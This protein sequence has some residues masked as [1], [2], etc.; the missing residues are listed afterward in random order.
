MPARNTVS[1]KLKACQLAPSRARAPSLAV[2]ALAGGAVLATSSCSSNGALAGFG[3]SSAAPTDNASVD[4]SSGSSSGGTSGF[5]SRGDEAGAG[6]PSLPPEMKVESAFRSPV[7]TGQV[8]WVANP[9]SGRVAYIDA[10]NFSVQTVQAGNGPTYLAAVPDPK[11]DV[12]IVINTVSQDA[13]L[14]RV[15]GGT[16]SSV[17]YPST[18][19]ANSWAISKSGR[20]A[21]AWTNSSFVRAAAP[22]DGFQEVAVLDLSGARKPQNLIVGFRPSQ[23]VFSGDESR[24]FAVTQDGIS[25]VDLTGGSH[26]TITQ[27]FALV[28]PV[29]AMRA[30][31]STVDAGGSPG[32]GAT[33]DAPASDASAGDGPS[34]DAGLGPE[35]DAS[36]AL[37]GI[38]DV[39]FT[40]TGSYALVRIDGV[41]AIN[42]ISLTDGT[43]T[44]VPLASA[45]T[46]L[47]MSPA[48][49]FALA[50]MRDISTVAVLPLPGIFTDPSVLTQVKIPNETI[51]RAIVTNGGHTAVLFTTVAPVE[52]LTVLTLPSTAFRTVPLHASVRAVFPTDDGQNAIVLHPA[53]PNDTAQGAFSVVPIGPSLP[54][55]IVSLPAPPIAVS[56][57][58]TSDYGLVSVSDTTT[59]FRLY[60]VRMPSLEVVPYTLASAPTAVGIVA[61]AGQGYAA[62][63]YTEGRITFVDPIAQH[64]DASSSCSRTITGFELGAR[65][66]NGSAP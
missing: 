47:T 40:P 2:W 48:G 61:Q 24:A 10:S 28:A 49:D 32:D 25:V 52:R 35:F 12:A 41:A 43:S 44:S 45:P 60:L 33:G 39:S 11:D 5:G 38:P 37:A 21:I 62:Q 26:P 14:L 23:V 53:T 16:L 57:A 4:A 19:D 27:N 66:V 55:N 64:C 63:D 18:A 22:T 15:S 65:V 51:G 6:I 54:A 20:W 1:R 13:T 50:V 3:G 30:D 58:P 46:D 34:V 36:T 7:A 42:V 9:T 56:L 59:T 29:A 8:V 31:A 17:S